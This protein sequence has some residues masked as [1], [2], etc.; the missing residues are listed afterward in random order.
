MPL[1]QTTKQWQNVVDVVKRVCTME[2][3]KDKL[4]KLYY[5]IAA[6]YRDEIKSAEDAVECFNLALDNSLENLKAFEAIDKILTQQKDWKQLERN[7]RKMIHRIAGKGK[8]D[9]EI[10]LWHFLGEIYRTRMGQFEAAAE[11]FKMASMLDPDNVTRHEIL[12]ELYTKMPDKLEDAVAQHLA[13][14]EQ[15]PYKVDSYKAL[16]RLYFE[17]RQYDKAWCLC[18]TLAFLKKADAEEQQ[19]FEQYR[20]RGTVRAQARLDN[21]RWIKDLFHKDESVYVGKIFEIVTRAVRS[22][23]I[24]PIK[25]FGL[26]KT[27]KRAT[28]DTLMISKT[29]FYVAQVIN[30]PVVPELYLQEESPGG[31]NFAVTEPMASACGSA[32]LTGYSPQD[33]LF[34]VTKHLTYYRPEHYLRWVLP[35]HGE[36]KGLMLAC[37]KIG[38]PGM[39][40]PDKDGVVG[41]WQRELE[42]I[43]TSMEVDNLQKVVARFV[44]SGE[45]ADLKKWIR[46]LELT[47]CRAGF[48]LS[49]DLETAAKMIQAETTAVDDLSP[50]EKIKELVLFSVSEE[51]FRLREAMGIIIGT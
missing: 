23:K 38:N 25:N 32:L 40:I 29:F 16:R 8:K 42:K 10:N 9:I 19:F 43:M 12:A 28:N 44:K 1:Y 33:L 4:A 35:S 6:I 51:Y 7:Y 3:D 2:E 30:L 50:K 20:T 45:Q 22:L 11:A 17:H 15:N 49:N 31:L 24:Q 5:T 18:A 36:L 39:N 14:I 26:K 34:L 48:L 13:L 37:L 47:A 27:Q 41:Q 46:S 21:E